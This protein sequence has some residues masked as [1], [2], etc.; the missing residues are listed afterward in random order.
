[1]SALRA[2]IFS[3]SS[4]LGLTAMAIKGRTFG[5]KNRQTLFRYACPFAYFTFVHSLFT[6]YY[7]LLCASP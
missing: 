7:F 3:L 4:I 6:I 2:S 1:M 5:A